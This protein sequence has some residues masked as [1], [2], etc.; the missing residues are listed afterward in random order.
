MIAVAPLAGTWIETLIPVPF[1]CI[2]Q[3]FP[4][5]ERGLKLTKKCEE[6]FEAGS[7]PL[8]ERGLKHWT[9]GQKANPFLS[10]PLRER[11]LKH[12]QIDNHKHNKPRRSPCGNVD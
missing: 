10:F 8:R 2:H 5:R 7:F 6:Q 1:L 3:S 12:I 4:L 9:R 11:G